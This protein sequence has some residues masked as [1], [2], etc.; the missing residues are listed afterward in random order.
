LLARF[1][2]VVYA[3]IGLSWMPCFCFGVQVVGQVARV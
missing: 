3:G 2:C 1:D